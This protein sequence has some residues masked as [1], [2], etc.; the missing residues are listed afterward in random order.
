MSPVYKPKSKI[1]KIAF[2]LAGVKKAS[3]TTLPAQVLN[4]VTNYW[5]MLS[6]TSTVFSTIFL[7]ITAMLFI[8]NKP[9][10]IYSLCGLGSILCAIKTWVYSRCA[11]ETLAL[12]KQKKREGSRM[13]EQFGNYP[14]IKWMATTA[15]QFIGGGSELQVNPDLA[16]FKLVRFKDL[17]KHPKISEERNF[18]LMLIGSSKT[19]IF[20][21]GPDLRID[22][23]IRRLPYYNDKSWLEIKNISL[24]RDFISCKNAYTAECDPR[25]IDYT[26]L[27]PLK[28][29]E[30]VPELEL[31]KVDEIC[32]KCE[33]FEFNPRISS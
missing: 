5:L 3:S 26:E 22:E 23:I 14:A 24:E 7:T 20:I 16:N 29:G 12:W 13:F 1:E 10:Y 30:E 33:N 21:D 31:T 11:G 32:A 8:E 9:W 15:A 4:A 28:P 18:K 19:N 27:K 6:N 2:R 17:R 25:V